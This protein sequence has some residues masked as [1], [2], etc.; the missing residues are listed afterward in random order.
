MADEV[1]REQVSVSEEDRYRTNVNYKVL[2][3]M[4]G[5]ITSRSEGLQDVCDYSDFYIWYIL[6]K[7]VTWTLLE[8]FTSAFRTILFYLGI[9]WWNYF[10]VHVVLRR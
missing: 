4:A 10:V 5:E 6:V 2:D 1:I 8:N 7:L 3:S 9:S